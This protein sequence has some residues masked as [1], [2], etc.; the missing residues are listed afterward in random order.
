MII[1]GPFQLKYSK[2]YLYIYACNGLFGSD[3]KKEKYS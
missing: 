2:E 1:A 3:I